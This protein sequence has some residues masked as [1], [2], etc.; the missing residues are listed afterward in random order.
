MNQEHKKSFFWG[1]IGLS[2]L[3][4]ALSAWNYASSYA[5]S[6]QP[7][8]FRSFAV[9]GEGK[10][11]AVPDIAQISFSVLTEGNKDLGALQSQNTEKMNKVIAFLKGQ[12]VEEKD[13]KTEQYNISPRYQYYSCPS[14]TY[15][16]QP[17]PPA[18]IVGSTINQN[19]EVKIRD[20]AKIGSVLGG[21]VENG[22]NTVSQLTF[23][24]DDPTAVEMEARKEA[25]EKAKVKA[26]EIAEAGG[27]N[28]GRLLSVDENNY[29]P[30]PM[31][32][33]EALGMGGVAMDSAATPNI[34]P[35]SQEVTVNVVL[36]YEIK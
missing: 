1:V 21:L 25:M 23:A 26:E 2:V 35:G 36:R 8:S 20:F 13:I 33:K 14:Q 10:V 3:M 31:M 27:F 11:T 24:I 4:V 19:V 17:C 29:Y 18:D 12:G 15:S 28:V 34:Q 30:R 7:S 5:D 9:S 16:A 6:I 32:Y 22:A